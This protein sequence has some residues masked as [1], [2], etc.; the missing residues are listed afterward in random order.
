MKPFSCTEIWLPFWCTTP[1]KSAP[2][3]SVG[4]TKCSGLWSGKVS[5]HMPITREGPVI[6][7]NRPAFPALSLAL[8]HPYLLA[9]EVNLLPLQEPDFRV[10][11]GSQAVHRL[12]C[13]WLAQRYKPVR[14]RLYAQ[15]AT[16]KEDFLCRFAQRGIERIGA[17]WLIIS[18][19]SIEASRSTNE[20][21]KRLECGSFSS[22]QPKAE[23]R[24]IARRPR[25]F[26][27]GSALWAGFA[28]GMRIG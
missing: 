16:D 26:H 4:N 21:W 11:H 27:H 2:H 17:C 15:A 20:A 22:I 1:P 14:L 23:G 12:Q 7:R 10:A 25:D 24:T 13:E 19:D 6:H 3:F 5:A 18:A 28:G 8:A 9:G